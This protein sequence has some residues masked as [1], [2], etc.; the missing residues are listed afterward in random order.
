MPSFTTKHYFYNKTI[1]HHT[2]PQTTT[3]FPPTVS[4][5]ALQSALQTKLPLPAH[6]PSARLAHLR[7][8]NRVREVVTTQ[9]ITNNPS[10]SAN[11]ELTPTPSATARLLRHSAV[12][13]KYLSWNAASAA[14]AEIIEF[15]EEAIE[16]VKLLVGAN[17]FSVGHDTTH[18]GEEA[19]SFDPE[20][21]TDAQG[22]DD[23]DETRDEFHDGGW[24]ERSVTLRQRRG[25]S[26]TARSHSSIAEDDGGEVPISLRRIQSRKLEAGV[27]RQRSDS[28]GVA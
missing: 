9:T 22:D 26:N 4:L 19:T 5:F 28:R 21:Q 6:L 16:L 23:A 18:M 8:I 17:E 14:R 2:L 1:L 24:I 11:N 7:M 25:R 20:G 12:R 27:R 10:T 15:L 3:N 13:K